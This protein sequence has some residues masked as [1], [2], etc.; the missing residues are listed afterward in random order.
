M[1]SKQSG[2]TL[3]GFLLI[4]VVVGFFAYMAMKLAPS[5]S[6]YMGVTKAMNQIATEGTNGKSLDSIRRDLMFK[7]G[8]QYV[9]DATVKPA[10]ITIKR[11]AGGT[12]VLTVAYDKQIPFMYN[13]DFLLHFNK[14]VP[15]QGNV[16]E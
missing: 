2:I 8:F 3:I 1:K 14:S 13:I 5:Y 16:G 6:E 11:D 9:D 12:S 10:N 4:I 15:L 7:L